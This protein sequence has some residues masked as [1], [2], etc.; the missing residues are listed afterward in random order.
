MQEKTTVYG[1]VR[2]KKEE[3]K[4]LNEIRDVRMR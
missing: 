2:L 4:H 1:E 3:H